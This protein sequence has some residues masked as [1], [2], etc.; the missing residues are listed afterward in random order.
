MPIPDLSQLQKHCSS[1]QIAVVL[2]PE[3]RRGEFKFPPASSCSDQQDVHAW[4]HTANMIGSSAESQ[5]QIN[6]IAM[7][8]IWPEQTIFP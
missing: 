5:L 4:A 1:K 6:S 8:Q 3:S 7:I 2:R